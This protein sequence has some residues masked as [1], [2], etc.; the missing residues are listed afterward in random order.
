[1]LSISIFSH[2]PSRGLELCRK[3]SKD[4]TVSLRMPYI[5]TIAVPGDRCTPNLSIYLSIGSQ[6]PEE[7]LKSLE[8]FQSQRHVR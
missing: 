3:A 1:M 2:S 4:L 8:I 7:L 5:Y 6:K